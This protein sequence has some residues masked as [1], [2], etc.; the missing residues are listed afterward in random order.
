MS[1]KIMG[2]VWDTALK[3]DQKFV[4]LAYAD[5]ADHEGYNVRPGY[6]LI[7]WKTGYTR[8]NVMRIVSELESLGV[9]QVVKRGGSREDGTLG[10]PNEWFINIEAAPKTQPRIKGGRVKPISPQGETYDTLMRVKSSSPDPL[11]KPPVEPSF[12]SAPPE[13]HANANA[14]TGGSGANGSGGAGKVIE[15][16]A[17]QKTEQRT[18][19]KE[20]EKEKDYIPA[21]V[22]NITVKTTP[23]QITPDSKKVAPRAITVQLEFAEKIASGVK[24]HEVRDFRTDYRGLI[25][26]T[27]S[28]AKHAI[29]VVELV[30]IVPA[31]EVPELSDKERSYGKWAWALKNPRYVRP[32][33]TKGQLGLWKWGGELPEV[34][35]AEQYAAEREAV[36]V[37]G[38]GSGIGDK[39]IKLIETWQEEVGRETIP[40]GVKLRSFARLGK[41]LLTDGVTPEDMACAGQLVKSWRD[42]LP[43]K[44]AN[45]IK[46]DV[47]STT[48]LIRTALMMCKS[49][50]C[51][52]DV[53]KFTRDKYA[54]TDAN[55]RRFWAGKLVSFDYVGANIGVWK[56]IESSGGTGEIKQSDWITV[57]VR[58]EWGA[59]VQ[60]A[61]H[62]SELTKIEWRAI[63]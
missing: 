33:A 44:G 52:D 41:D 59:E 55:G 35:T 42:A 60:Q 63:Q 26:V 30:D 34:I 53:G 11:S 14:S 12:F 49:G 46:W 9:M 13:A 51:G 62:K 2:A 38:K 18:H 29:C 17:D 39:H 40:P 61:V 54:E 7:A 20:S 25:V 8:R 50:V 16:D 24:T 27:V 21:I 6:D 36:R 15:T 4:L 48:N 22:N 19:S 5:H 32:V 57:W 45:V 28:K 37:A 47:G 3:R 58:T 43:V 31:S 1:G 23:D 56:G 10:K